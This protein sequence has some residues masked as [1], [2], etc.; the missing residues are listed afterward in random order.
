MSYIGISKR[1]LIK[2]SIND[3]LTNYWYTVFLVAFTITFR[4]G[5]RSKNTVV[6]NILSSWHKSNK[7]CILVFG[8]ILFL[9]YVNEIDELMFIC[10]LFKKIKRTVRPTDFTGSEK[11]TSTSV[12]LSIRGRWKLFPIKVFR[13][14]I[15]SAWDSEL[16]MTMRDLPDRVWKVT[17]PTCLWMHFQNLDFFFFFCIEHE[18]R[19]KSICSISED[20]KDWIKEGN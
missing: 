3:C 14:S 4:A 2:S 19:Y 8:T 1:R 18:Q 13:G 10:N 15:A 11:G 7:W 6:F 17:L 20:Q 5:S 12:E 16:T 9:I